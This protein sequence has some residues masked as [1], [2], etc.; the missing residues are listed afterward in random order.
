[1]TRRAAGSPICANAATSSRRRLRAIQLPTKR[2]VVPSCAI[3]AR[4]GSRSAPGV[5]MSATC[6]PSRRRA[7]VAP[8]VAII[9][10]L[11]AIAS[12]SRAYVAARCDPRGISQLVRWWTTR[13][14]A[15][16]RIATNAGPSSRKRSSSPTTT[17]RRARSARASRSPAIDGARDGA[18]ETTSPRRRALGA[19]RRRCDRRRSRPSADRASRRPPTD[20]AWGPH[21]AS[22]QSGRSN[23]THATGD[24]RTTTRSDD[25][26]AGDAS[27]SS[28]SMCSATRLA[29]CS[30]TRSVVEVRP[31]N[32]GCSSRLR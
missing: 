25:P 16:R 29:T 15:A 12:R 30:A 11:A 17:S 14:R 8:L 4:T 31:G 2:S 6:P 3:R 27:A 26:D 32:A 21:G 20:S 1:M 5:A 28:A 13:T 7:A 18:I 22:A 23:A 10:S 9:A 24:S 19:P